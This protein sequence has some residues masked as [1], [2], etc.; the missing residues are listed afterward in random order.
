MMFADGSYKVANRVTIWIVHLPNKTKRASL[1]TAL[2]QTVRTEYSCNS[3]FFFQNFLK[4]E[5]VTAVL[6]IEMVI[7]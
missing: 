1:I 7:F 3:F 4:L 2:D 5:S 6:D